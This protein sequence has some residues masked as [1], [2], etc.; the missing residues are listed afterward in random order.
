MTN[1]STDDHPIHLHRHT[2]E[3]TRLNGTPLSGLNKDVLVVPA[4]EIA[5]VDFTAD[6]PG[7]TLFHCH[8]QTHMD[9]GFMMMFRYV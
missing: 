8:S 9:F 1:R 7:P 3:V 2:F 6:N 4:N 5:E